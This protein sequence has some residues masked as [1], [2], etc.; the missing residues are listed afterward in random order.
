VAYVETW[1]AEMES[2]ADELW[3]DANRDDTEATS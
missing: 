3:Q 1:V 2:Q